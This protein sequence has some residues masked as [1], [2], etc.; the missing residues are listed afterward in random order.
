[1]AAAP[2]SGAKAKGTTSTAA[3]DDQD[4]FDALSLTFGIL[5]VVVASLSG[6][7]ALIY[8]MKKEELAKQQAIAS[9][10]PESVEFA[11]VKVVNGVI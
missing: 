11:P 10:D 2:A 8:G 7:F 4:T 9:Y 3:S 5:I 6:I 1:M